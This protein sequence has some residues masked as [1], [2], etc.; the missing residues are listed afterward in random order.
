[1][2]EKNDSI[3]LKGCVEKGPQSAL[4]KQLIE[5]FLR[6]Q[7]YRLEDL[8]KLDKTLAHKLMEEACK[9]ASSKLSEIEAKAGFR[10]KIKYE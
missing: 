4:E 10:Q 6:E 2:A 1:M 3:D 5:G 8:D 7:G 9:Y